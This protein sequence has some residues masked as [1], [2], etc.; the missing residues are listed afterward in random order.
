MAK[1]FY[2]R[3]MTAGR[4]QKVVRYSRTLPGDSKVT[5][6]AKQTATTAAQKFI[7]TKNTTQRLELLLCA[8]FDSKEACFCT[9]TFSANNLPANQKHTKRMFSDYIRK[10]RPEFK[11]FGKSLLYIYTVE[12]EPLSAAPSASPVDSQEWEITPWRDKEHWEQIAHTGPQE[13]PEK[14]VRLHIHC[15]L[16]LKREEYDT[17]RALWPYGQVYINQM[18]VNEITTFQR[19]AA[20]VTK[21]KRTGS[22]G[23]GERAYIPSANLV[24][25]THE[26]HWCSEY[27]GLVLPSGAEKIASGSEE[28]SI[29]GASMEFLYYRLPRPQEPPQPY[30]SKGTV[31]PGRRKKPRK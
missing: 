12:G 20:Y 28:Q 3:T 2:I 16:L 11:R 13:T 4:Y 10:L 19:L 8:N 29:Y 5:R 23:N 17:V 18:K 21:E 26:G 1:G 24:Q 6:Q 31:S 22:K 15:F 30:K 7:N 27:E 14:E 25:P 9:F